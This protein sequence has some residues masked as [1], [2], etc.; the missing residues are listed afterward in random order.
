MKNK[1][2]KSLWAVSLLSF[3]ATAVDAR[4]PG[5]DPQAR[6]ELRNAGLDRYV[7]KF[8]P[9]A[10]EVMGDWDKYTFDTE[11]GDGPICIAGTPLTVFHQ[12]REAKK[13]LV[14]L[15]GGGACVQNSYACSILADDTPP[16]DSGIFADGFAPFGIDNPLADWSKLFVSYCDGS[17]FSGDNELEDPNFPVGP[18]RYHRG[19]R[20]LTAALDLARDLHPNAKQVMLSGISAGGYGVNNFA[21]SIYRL[22]FPPSA[23]LFVLNDS[24]PGLSNPFLGAVLQDNDWNFSQFYPESCVDCSPLPGA[25]QAAYLLWT[26]ENDRGYKGAL[27]STDGDSVIRSFTF[28]PTQQGY[29]DLLLDTTDPVAAAYPGRYKRFIRS[30][31]ED[32]TA[33]S[34]F[35]YYLFEANTV[36]LYQWVGEF[37]AGGPGW[38]DIVEDF[39]PAP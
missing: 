33:L 6:K 31:S 34:F 7:G 19:V 20:N 2:F 10:P 4:P 5:L 8:K 38:V 39:V 13:L 14:V 32:H 35:G 12:Q 36:P 17:V 27:Y 30:G 1:L 9:G 15:D 37:I 28:I 23:D 3:A 25:N 22:I 24:G 29:R 11:N 26:L 16:G 18:V 21:P